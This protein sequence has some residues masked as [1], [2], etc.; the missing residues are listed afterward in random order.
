MS[1]NTLQ[2]RW[3]VTIEGGLDALFIDD[4]N[5]FVAG[6]LLWYPVEGKPTIRSAPDAMVVFGRPKG[7][8]GS[9]KQWEEG[10]IAP[11]SSSRSSRPAT[12]PERWNASSSSTSVMASRNTTSTTRTAVIWSAGV[13]VGDN[14]GRDPQHGRFREPSAQDPLRARRRTRQPQDH[15]PR[16]RAVSD[17]R[18][19]GQATQR[20]SPAPRT[21]PTAED[22]PDSPRN[23]PSVPTAWPRGCESWASNRIETI[24]HDRDHRETASSH[25]SARAA[26]SRVG[27]GRQTGRRQRGE[28]EARRTEAI[29]RRRLRG[30]HRAGDVSG[31][32][33]RRLPAKPRH[34]ARTTRFVPSAWS[35]TTDRPGWRSSWSIVA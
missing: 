35:S 23:K 9:Y 24:R 31:L 8:R 29:P 33:Q 12:V 13:R 19:I 6:D 1:D 5:V 20:R 11:R 34:P 27:H 3:I 25:R 21:T 7:D 26:C 4:P 10:G 22:K 17:L 14:S 16:R 28:S 2:F 32:R 15:R 18:G 30:R